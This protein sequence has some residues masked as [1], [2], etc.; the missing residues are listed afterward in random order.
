[1]NRSHEAVLKARAQIETLTPIVADAD[2]HA[3]RSERAET[4]RGCREALTPWFASL[5]MEL[6]E[7]RL[8]DLAREQASAADKVEELKR[9]RGEQ[10]RQRDELRQAI[11]EHGGDRLE[12]ISEEIE[13]RRAEK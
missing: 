11:A 2:D 8:A 10:R 12:R 9:R 13:R 5:K 4:L 6:L 7:H 3:A 1:L